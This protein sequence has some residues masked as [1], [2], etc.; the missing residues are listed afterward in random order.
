[1]A[2]DPGPIKVP[3]ASDVVANVIRDQFVNGRF[4]PGDTLPSESDLAV[5]YGVSRPVVREA[6]RIL[7]GESLIE[8][9]RGSRGGA[10][11]TL[12]DS[13]TLSGQVSVLLQLQGATISDLFQA[14][15]VIEPAVV[16][17]LADACEDSAIEQLKD[18]NRQA[19]RVIDS[20]D[21][22]PV[23]SSD[24]HDQLIE[25]TGN[26]TLKLFS[27]L[28]HRIVETHNRA[29]YALLPA[30]G[31]DDALVAAEYHE[32]L[33]DLI[34]E[35]DADGAEALWREHLSR[36]AEMT[37]ERLGNLSVTQVMESD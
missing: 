32:R 5:Q 35:G 1:M 19:R 4:R 14:R 20:G 10:R 24:F 8:M 6:L 2:L 16:R 31:R 3:K 37:Y 15:L 18:R 22:Y 13:S 26:L 23:D 9:R 21:R 36:T 11:F 7:E 17:Q 12:P 33:V 29:T 28:I 27:Q 25:M 30:H 34:V